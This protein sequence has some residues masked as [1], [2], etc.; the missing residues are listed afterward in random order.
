MNRTLLIKLMVTR[1]GFLQNTE[2]LKILHGSADKQKV[3]TRKQSANTCLIKELM[4]EIGLTSLAS[5]KR[6]LER[7]SK[8]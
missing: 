2:F 3:P 8:N 4:G 7:G 5:A 1:K 6:G